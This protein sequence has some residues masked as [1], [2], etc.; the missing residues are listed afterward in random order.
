MSTM[1]CSIEEPRAKAWIAKSNPQLKTIRY[2][3]W[4]ENYKASTFR[5]VICKKDN[6][7]ILEFH[8]LDPKK[9]KYNIS[10]MINNCMRLSDIQAELKKCVVLCSNC[11]AEVERNTI[12]QDEMLRKAKREYKKHY[13]PG[14]NIFE[15][16]P[17]FMLP[18]DNLRIT[19]VSKYSDEYLR[20]YRVR[21]NLRE[22]EEDT[23]P[24]LFQLP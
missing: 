20:N 16:F 6:P 5:C 21:L 24:R 11:H 8:H 1:T 14:E 10:T 9:K 17:E 22:T 7:V 3:Y 12:S 2:K 13:R 23:N 4:F 19:I 18:T 15:D